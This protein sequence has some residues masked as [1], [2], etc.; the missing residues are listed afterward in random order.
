MFTRYVLPVVALIGIVVGIY[1]VSQWRLAVSP[2]KIG[3]EKRVET[4]PQPDS[5]PPQQPSELL[6]TIYGAGLVEAQRENIPIG[7]PVPGVVMEV[8][9]DGRPGYDPPHK[10]VGDRVK[11]G[12]PLFRID[13]RDLL[14]ELKVRKASLE[15]AEAQLQRLVNMPRA[16]DLPPA[17]A[18]VE[19][20]HARLMDAQATYSRDLPLYQKKMIAASDFDKDKYAML[21]AKAALAR[22]EADLAKLKAGAWKEDIAVQQSACEQAR[23]QIESMNIMLA[24]LVVRAPVDGEVLQVNVRPGQFAAMTWKEPMIV[25]GEVNRLHV[26]VD[27]DEIDLNRFREGT[28]AEATLRGRKEPRF[29]LEYIRIE[30]YVIPKRSLTGDNS[31][32]VDTRALQVLYALPDNSPAK[33]YV[34]QQMDVFLA[35]GENQN[36]LVEN[37]TQT[38]QPA[39]ADLAS[40]VQSREIKPGAL[41]G[42]A[43]R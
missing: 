38:V 31:E 7:T 10:K 19:E 21:A 4:V 12:E 36:T 13:D 32:R 18:A 41:S 43:R 6:N 3:I 27:I 22:A 42:T 34:G 35:V 14:A 29:N 37:E 11:K 25:L 8:Y 17:I 9:V 26:R 30:P 33:V 28:R 1:G 2:G 5:P 16:E 20:A 24:R 39:V 23:S 15:A 40:R